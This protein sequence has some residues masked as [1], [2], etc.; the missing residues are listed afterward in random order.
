MRLRVRRVECNRFA[1][2][3]F[4]F[5]KK[6]L[7][8]QLMSTN[9]VELRMGAGIGL[10]QTLLRGRIDFQGQ[11]AERTLVIVGADALERN[12]LGCGHNGPLG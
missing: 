4:R 12:L 11:Q 2:F 8:Q 5:G 3:A 7:S 9:G 6:A 1:E 10:G